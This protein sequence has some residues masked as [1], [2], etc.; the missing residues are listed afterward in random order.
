M[1]TVISASI[2]NNYDNSKDNDHNQIIGQLFVSSKK[3]LKE[4]SI[5]ETAFYEKE[6]AFKS[7]SPISID[8]HYNLNNKF[9]K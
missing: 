2:M 6:A 7:Q 8:V 1:R 9:S 5:G 3:G 4:V